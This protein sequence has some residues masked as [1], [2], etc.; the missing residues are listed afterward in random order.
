MFG[1]ILRIE[2][3]NDDLGREADGGFGWGPV[4]RPIADGLYRLIN[5]GAPTSGMAPLGV[6]LALVLL[7]LAA[8]LLAGAFGCRRPL[9]A[10][11][12]AAGLFAQPYGLANLSFQFDAPLMAAAQLLAI[13]AACWGLACPGP[14]LRAKTLLPQVLLLVLSLGLYQAA[15]GSSWVVLLSALALR[16]WLGEPQLQLGRRLLALLLVSALALGTYRFAVLPLRRLSAYAREHA[17]VAS[18]P[19]LPAALLA[20]GSKALGGAWGDWQATAPGFWIAGLLLLTLALALEPLRRRPCRAAALQAAALLLL[21]WLVCLGPQLALAQPV[22]D[23]RTFLPFGAVI[24]SAVLFCQ[25]A[26]RQLAAAG[27]L[28]ARTQRVLLVPQLA[29]VWSLAVTAYSY[30]MPLP[31]SAGS[32]RCCSASSAPASTVCPRSSGGSSARSI[33]SAVCPAAPPQPRPSGA[34]RPSR[35]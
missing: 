17:A 29:L 26:V 12:A 10:A 28:P 14:P 19:D 4:G 5:S 2:A 20:H 7:A 32:K 31:S 23:A 34:S 9:E 11:L 3:Y 15:F 30:T 35:A 27:A 1:L 24:A 22:V 8:T 25:E 6:L 13:S 33:S 16:R 21:A 18:L